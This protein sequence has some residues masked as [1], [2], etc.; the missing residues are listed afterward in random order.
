MV[1]V[2]IYLAVIVI[3]VA[4]V[5]WG[6][7]SG[8]LQHFFKAHPQIPKVLTFGYIIFAGSVI[9]FVSLEANDSFVVRI[10]I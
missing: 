4:I 5:Y 2:A 3:L 7:K 8:K 1:F 9:K 6:A 10:T